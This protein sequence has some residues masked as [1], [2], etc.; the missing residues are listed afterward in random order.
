MITSFAQKKEKQEL[1]Y[2]LNSFKN[3]TVLNASYNVSKQ[4]IWDAVYVMMKQEYKEIK[5]QDFEKGII[6]GYD[7]GDTF[8]EGFTTEIIGSGPYR[9]VFTMNRQIRYINKDR[10]YTGWY[11]KNEIPQDYLFKIQNSIY[12]TL[13]GSFKYSPELINEIDAYNASQ[14][15]DKY[16]LVLGKDY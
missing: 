15:K 6:E 3:S 13:Y 12:T 2:K 7:Q 10:S 8:K 16:K 9:V 11:D 4:Q 1:I 14:T 5:K